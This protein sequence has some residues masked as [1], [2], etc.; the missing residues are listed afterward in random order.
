MLGVGLAVWRISPLF[1][2]WIASS[3]NFLFKCGFIDK[4]ATVLE[5]GCGIS[6]VLAMTVAPKVQRY[7]TTD[8][9]Y[10]SNILHPTHRSP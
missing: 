9:D 10:V 8:Q 1:A 5:L 6:G 2:E 7:I 3:N 4:E